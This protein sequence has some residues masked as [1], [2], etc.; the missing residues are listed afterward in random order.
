MV[1]VHGGSNLQGG[2]KHDALDACADGRNVL[3]FSLERS[4]SGGRQHGDAHGSACMAHASAPTS[5]EDAGVK[6]ESGR[7][8]GGN[9]DEMDVLSQLLI[10]GRQM[11][12]K[13]DGMANSALDEAPP[14]ATS[15]ASLSI[16]AS[17][18]CSGVEHG[19]PRCSTQLSHADALWLHIPS[20]INDKVS[21]SLEEELGSSLQMGDYEEVH[22]G[23]VDDLCRVIDDEDDASPS[24]HGTSPLCGTN[25]HAVRHRQSSLPGDQDSYVLH[26]K[27]T[28]RLLD[29]SNCSSLRTATLGGGA[30]ESVGGGAP[31]S[32]AGCS[33]FALS[34]HVSLVSIGG[35]RATALRPGDLIVLDTVATVP[36]SEGDVISATLHEQL[37]IP[38]PPELPDGA[39]VAVDKAVS[40]RLTAAQLVALRQCSRGRAAGN[41][42]GADDKVRGGLELRVLHQPR[43]RVFG[44]VGFRDVGEMIAVGVGVVDLEGLWALSRW[45]GIVHLRMCKGHEGRKV[46]TGNDRDSGILDSAKHARR[47]VA[48]PKTAS[49]YASLSS[50]AHSSE[51]QQHSAHAV[52]GRVELAVSLL[53]CHR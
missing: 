19:A 38:V 32:V 9:G 23:L 3:D 17:Q 13:L 49:R 40:I 30:E 7:T 26:S 39:A 29:A 25:E 14:E 33:A 20:G 37:R 35:G 28:Q 41:G 45:A 36:A 31:A 46:A 6:T 44:E 11:L 52:V 12:S 18:H 8:C 1:D 51:G 4:R 50:K 27:M 16:G 42:R 53:A 22:A 48:A 2:D 21:A 34:V 24:A 15:D 43:S 10:K 47:P 5:Q